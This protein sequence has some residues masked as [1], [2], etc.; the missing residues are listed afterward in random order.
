MACGCTTQGQILL[1]ACPSWSPLDYWETKAPRPSKRVALRSLRP[2]RRDQWPL[3]GSLRLQSRCLAAHT[4]PSG[5]GSPCATWW[6]SFSWLV[7]S[8]MVTAPSSLSSQLRLHH[9]ACHLGAMEGAQ[10]QDIPIG[11]HD[12]IDAV[13]THCRG[14]QRL[15]GSR[16]RCYVHLHGAKHL[17]SLC[18]LSHKT[19]CRT[20]A[21][22]NIGLV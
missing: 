2:R 3:A 12:T 20:I 13:P 1:L 19:C 16:F 14:G 15:D 22:C 11:V 6:C 7:A 5:L 18:S 8:G 9:V 10:P 4:Q 21:L 17:I